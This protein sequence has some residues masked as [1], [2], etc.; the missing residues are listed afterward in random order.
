VKPIKNCAIYT[1]KK[2]DLKKIKPRLAAPCNTKTS[3][4]VLVRERYFLRKNKKGDAINKPKKKHTE[5]I[6]I[7]KTLTKTSS[8]I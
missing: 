8:A 3:L 2:K 1:M 5:V 4:I 6:P 7:S